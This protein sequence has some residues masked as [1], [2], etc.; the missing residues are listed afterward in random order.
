MFLLLRI[1]FPVLVRCTKMECFVD[2]VTHLITAW[3]WLPK[4]TA[5][6]IK[7]SVFELRYCQLFW[8]WKIVYF[9]SKELL[10]LVTDSEISGI[11]ITHWAEAILLG[12]W[13][14]GN[15]SAD[16][17]VS[18]RR[19]PA[20][21]CCFPQWPSDLKSILSWVFEAALISLFV[22]SKNHLTLITDYL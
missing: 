15:R 4:D 16:M 3:K 12:E 22:E 20:T 10:L 6:F 13:L 5:I 1:V 8:T 7:W 14:L 9:L 18:L 2:S 21:F 11:F 19:P 17:T